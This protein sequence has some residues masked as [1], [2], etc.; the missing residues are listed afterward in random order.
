M[1][2]YPENIPLP[3]SINE[4]FY[5]AQIR[6]PFEDGS[7]QSR[8]KHTKGRGKWELSYDGI[9]IVDSYIIR[10][11]FYANQGDLFNWTNP[12]NNIT[13]IVR[14]SEDELQVKIQSPY[15]CSLSVKIEEV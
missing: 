12:M 3:E 5:K 15:N 6:T 10:D 13:Y 8:T 9:S 4:S 7:V 11:F 14:F 2:N 1:N